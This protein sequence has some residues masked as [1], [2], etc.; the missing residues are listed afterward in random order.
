MTRTV[1]SYVSS[2]ATCQRIKPSTQAPPGLLQPH[3]VPS[4]PWSHVSMDL[5]TDLPPSLAHDGRTYDSVV[6]FVCMLTKQAHFVRALKTITSQQLAHVFIDAVLSKK[7]LPHVMVSDRDPRITAAFWQTLFTSLGSKLNISTSH[8]PETDGQTENVHRSIEQI[9][10]AYVSPLHDDWATWLPIAEFAY[11]NH[12]HSST[13]QTP[14]FSNYGFHPLTPASLILPT[15]P[16]ID[17]TAASYLDNI[18]DIQITISRELELSKA[19]Q[20]VQANRHRRDVTFAIG[21]RVR[22][23]TDNITLA[24]HPSSKLQ[25][26]YLGPFSITKIISPVSYKLALPSSMARVHPVFHVS[27]LL[28][29]LENPDTEFPGRPVPEQPIR[30]A[31]D[32]VYGDTFEVDSILDCKVDMDPTSRARPKADSLFFRVKWSP[33][34]SDPS[35]DSWEPLRSVSRLDAFKLF[36]NSTAWRQFAVTDAYKAFAMKYKSKIPKAVH[37]VLPQI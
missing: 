11:N 30:A 2:C 7:G 19:Q 13:H 3:S 16:A 6:T 31:R 24:E 9:L 29:W 14:F 12:V 18:R 20:T 25:P 35:H 1:R 5:I 17:A 21:D 22:L 32:F 4:R 33:P 36:L 34:Y 15:D 37:F 10:R 27:R 8:H 26:R 28:P 23:S